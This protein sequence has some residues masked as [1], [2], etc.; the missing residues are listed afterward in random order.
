MGPVSFVMVLMGC[1]SGQVS[2]APIAT[3]PVAYAS[4][5]SCLQSRGEILRASGDLGY[6]RVVAECRRNGA[7]SPA[8]ASFDVRATS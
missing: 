5:A 1:G 7:I 6:G 4:E 3:L 2:C 8:S